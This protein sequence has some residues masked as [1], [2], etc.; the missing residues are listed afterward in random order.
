MIA[1]A[2]ANAASRMDSPELKHSSSNGR[3]WM[4]YGS[5]SRPM[6]KQRHSN[7][8][9]APW[10]DRLFFLL[11]FGSTISESLGMI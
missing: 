4:T 2:A 5:N 3:I 10:R 6:V 8:H 11:I 7:P 1:S 9:N